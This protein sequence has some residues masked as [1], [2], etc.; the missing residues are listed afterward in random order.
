MK[1]IQ[2][3]FYFLIAWYLGFSQTE[4]K[5]YDSFLLENYD[6]ISSENL[7]LK[8]LQLENNYLLRSTLSNIGKSKEIK[9][10]NKAYFIQQSIGQGS[11]IGTFSGEGMVIRQGFIQQNF[12][13]RNTNNLKISELK[14]RFYPNPVK[15]LIN[16]TF[17]DIITLPLV[18]SIYD[19]A[20]KRVFLKKFPAS[21]QFSINT[22]G[23]LQGSYYLKISSNNKIFVGKLIKQ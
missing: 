22:N 23:L 13:K 21:Q 15:Q 19:Q 11:V 10:D 8:V 18:V 6:K 5:E 4:Y 17:D 16:I 14:A 12:Y 20:G 9:V 3:L 7:V 2:V 1:K